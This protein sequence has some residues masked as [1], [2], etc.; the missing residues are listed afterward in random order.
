MR[1]LRRAHPIVE[2]LGSAA[3]TVVAMGA[4]WQVAPADAAGSL[5]KLACTPLSTDAPLEAPQYAQEDGASG[6]T[7][8]WWC[9]LPH[10]TQVPA[11]FVERERLVSPIDYP[12]ADYSTYYG[13]AKTS[14]TA[15]TDRNGPGVEVSVDGDS[16][17]RLA[18]HLHYPAV[19]SGRHVRLAKGVTGTVV[20]D[21]QSVTVTWRYPR[22]GVPK[23]LAGV[24]AVTVAGSDVPEASVL[25]VARHVKP[26]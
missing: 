18:A 24:A 21:G 12:Y 2:I 19:A 22:T 14:P 25:A 10:A 4:V 15:L 7:D 26:D 5:H 6:G 11:N 16:S 20:K 1:A 9:E 13:T 17:P 23:Y 3:L 8:E